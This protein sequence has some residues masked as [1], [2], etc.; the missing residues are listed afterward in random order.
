MILRPGLAFWRSMSCTGAWPGCGLHLLRTFP[1]GRTQLVPLPP[2]PVEED[3]GVIGPMA[4]PEPGG[5]DNKEANSPKPALA[6]GTGRNDVERKSVSQPAAAAGQGL[7]QQ[8]RQ[9]LGTAKEEYGRAWNIA[10][11]AMIELIMISLA[12]TIDTAM[13]ATLGRRRWRR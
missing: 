10:W 1:A 4:P 8:E 12:A 9:T 3:P 2:K 11:P 7:S 6:A 13:V 5:A